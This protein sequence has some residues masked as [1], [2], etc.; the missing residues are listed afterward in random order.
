MIA[1]DINLTTEEGRKEFNKKYEGKIKATGLKDGG[2]SIVGLPRPKSSII[3]S[4]DKSLFK[5]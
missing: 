2:V 5:Q 3:S 4:N 1:D